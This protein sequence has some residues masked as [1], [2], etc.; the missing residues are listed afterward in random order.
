M[1]YRCSQAIIGGAREPIRCKVSGTVCAHQKY[2]LMEGKIVLT[3]RSLWCPARGGRL[4]P[5][6][7]EAAATGEDPSTPLRSAQ[8]DTG[9]DR[10]SAQDDTGE[11]RRSA[12][13]D[14]AEPVKKTTRKK[15]T[16]RKKV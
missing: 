10:R 5:D 14:T 3:D 1:A 13:D 12:Q 6:K 9:E 8:D 2:C 15:T 11:D 4:M 7:P 16:S